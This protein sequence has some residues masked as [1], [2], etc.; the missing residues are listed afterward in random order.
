MLSPVAQF[1]NEVA[2]RDDGPRPVDVA[3]RCQRFVE[4]D[5]ARRRCVLTRY[6]LE[7]RA[8]HLAMTAQPL[9]INVVSAANTDVR[10]D[11]GFHAERV[12]GRAR[13]ARI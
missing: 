8:S 4:A 12:S 6:P 2:P 10:A 3:S 5:D 7:N 9:G 13:D 11:L 1:E